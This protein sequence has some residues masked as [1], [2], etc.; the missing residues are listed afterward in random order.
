MWYEKMYKSKRDTVLDNLE[1]VIKKKNMLLN[2]SL[3]LEKNIVK[4]DD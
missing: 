4:A 2:I 3:F 1:Y